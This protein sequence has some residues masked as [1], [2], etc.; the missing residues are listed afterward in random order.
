MSKKGLLEW[1]FEQDITPVSPGPAT[2][3]IFSGFLGKKNLSSAAGV[4]INVRLSGR[5]FCSLSFR[6][7]ALG[8]KVPGHR[9]Q[10]LTERIDFVTRLAR[11]QILKPS[12]KNG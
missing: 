7:A 11:R 4:Q 5:T 1:A 6:C 10:M 12:R 8:A 9:H 3:S 2:N